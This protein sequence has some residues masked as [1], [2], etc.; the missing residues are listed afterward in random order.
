MTF[1]LPLIPAQAGIK[2]QPDTQV[3]IPAFA[4]VSGS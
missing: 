1:P 4:G 3:L 2:R